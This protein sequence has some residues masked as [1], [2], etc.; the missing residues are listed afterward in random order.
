MNVCVSVCKCVDV[1]ECVSVMCLHVC[2]CVSV[3][4]SECV[5]TSLSSSNPIAL[6]RCICKTGANDQSYSLVP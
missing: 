1:C 4:V 5:S 2:E 6:A 3:C